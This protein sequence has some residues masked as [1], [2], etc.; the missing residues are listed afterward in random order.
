MSFYRRIALV[1]AATICAPLASAQDSTPPHP[2]LLAVAGP[3]FVSAPTPNSPSVDARDAPA[4]QRRVT[5]EFDQVPLSA[6]LGQIAKQTGLHFGSSQ[7]LV[8]LDRTVSMSVSHITV[9]AALFELLNGMGIDVQLYRDGTTLVLVPRTSAPIAKR[10]Q[11]AGSI[12]GR[13]TDSG[14]RTPLSEV[15]V[16]VDGTTFSTT[17]N[18]DGKYMIAGVAPGT[19]RVTARRVGYQAISKDVTVTADQ[20]ATLDFS[21]VAAATKL[22]EIVTTAVGEQRRYEVGNV[23]STIN[24]D[25][26]TPTAPITSITDL[27]SA[28]APG[29]EVMEQSGITG[30]GPAIRIRGQ[31]SLLLQS[32][33]IIIVD[34][35]RQDNTP[36]T[37]ESLGGYGGTNPSPSRLNDLDFNDIETIDVLKGPAAS[38]EY[39]TDAA[40]GVIVVT[41]K[42]GTVGRPQWKVSAEQTES[43]IPVQFGA[44]YYSWGHTT[45]PS[46]TPI[47]CPLVPYVYNTDVGSAVG[48]CVVDSITNFDPLNDP[49]YSLYGGTGNR[50]KYDLSVGGGS[51]AI[52][53]FVSGSLSNETGIMQLPH[54]F[55]PEAD[56]LGLPASAY[57]PNAENQRSIRTN[58]SI[59]LGNTADLSANAAYLST[60][61]NAPSSTQ[62]TSGVVFN[63]TGQPPTPANNFG[64]AYPAGSP[65]YGFGQPISQQT[66]RLTGGLTANWRPTS[67]FVG[68]GTFGL[69]H[70][71]QVNQSELLP[72]V[73]PLYPYNP[74]S[75]AIGNTTNDIYTVDLRGAI[76]AAVTHNVRSVT[77]V[78]MQLVDTR[79][80]GLA[81]LANDLTTTNQTLNGAVNPTVTQLGDR[82]ATLGGYADEE[83]GLSDRLFVDGAVRIDAASGF[84]SNY[85]VAVYPKASISWLAL[86]SA[87]TTVRVRAAFGESGVQP[88]N[89]SALQLYAPTVDIA[90]GVE[91]PTVQI[92]NVQNQNLKPERSLEYEGGVDLSLLHNRVSVDLTGYS[93][94]TNDALVASGTGWELG[95]LS[96]EENVGE[97]R[98]TGVEGTISATILQRRSL[99]WDVTLNGS[100][101]HNK[102][103]TLAPGV[104]P[105]LN[106]RYGYFQFAAGYPLYG[107]W[108]PQTQYSDANGDGVLEPDE[109]TVGNTLVFA[110]SSLPTQE[111][112]F[113]THVSLWN[114]A[115]SLNALLDYRGG[116]RD[117]DLGMWEGAGDQKDY[118]SNFK[119]AP[120]WEQARDLATQQI[121]LTGVNGGYP[122]PKGYYEDGT[123]VRFRELSLTYSLPQRLTHSLRMQTLSITGAVRNLALWTRYLGADP[124]VSNTGGENVTLSPTT[125][126]DSVNNDFRADN[127]AI[128]LLRYWVV[129]L[130]LGI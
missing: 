71:S 46:H 122:P 106:V 114:G 40:N 1:A 36:G 108:A 29:V 48:T 42:H 37:A 13:V 69:D 61:Q 111:A 17:A 38:T 128:P 25:S 66:D 83:L 93:K 116:F 30:S 3:R 84:G 28:R 117:A 74:A 27:I 32:D 125:N 91:I 10:Q 57:R 23:I 82:E 113:S 124:E 4:F 109:V 45:D 102:L 19:Y 12:E 9:G 105:Q 63:G 90:G 98:N 110:G 120:L 33:P 72:Q 126:T 52:R 44:M 104:P 62:L 5:L 112:S 107:Y 35:V 6:A 70:G 127:Q 129:R 77:S 88:P 76:T 97:V 39:G 2:V 15:T 64:Y 75:L 56:S 16:R 7:E 60:Y 78:G 123:Y 95:S 96:Y 67:W 79:Q 89:G 119:S 101:N 21:L 34:G 87:Q 50:G 24:A 121:S 14:L 118:A 99:T 41:T 85:A 47:G 81:T 80:Q 31:S 49:A 103:V 22:D 18:A 58:T 68:H 94:T 92:S 54:V 100:V 20:P 59:K 55:Y 26:I 130:N 43:K 73:V 86:Q 53:Y 51:E 115:V 11:G 8:S 65:P